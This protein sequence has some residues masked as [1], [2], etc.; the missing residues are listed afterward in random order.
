MQN[1]SIYGT[2]VFF[3]S[4]YIRPLCKRY[5]Y[6][7][8]QRNSFKIKIEKHTSFNAYNAAAGHNSLIIK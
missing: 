5:F 8:L 6:S 2:L 4:S 7:I 3:T 1:D